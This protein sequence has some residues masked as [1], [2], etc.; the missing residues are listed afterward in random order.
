M[1]FLMF[2]FKYLL[3][4][5]YPLFRY[6]FSLFSNNWKWT[7]ILHNFDKCGLN[8]CSFFKKKENG[9]IRIRIQEEDRGGINQRIK[10]TFCLKK[11]SRVLKCLFSWSL[12]CSSAILIF[13][14]KSLRINL[15]YKSVLKRLCPQPVFIG[16]SSNNLV[17]C[18]DK[19]A[20]I[21]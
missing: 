16:L 10:Q 19:E 7:I 17:W 6:C 15:T 8:A 13:L 12:N 2:P 21:F 18:G 9:W 1:N 14:L 11:N 20:S 4:F 5:Q 3:K